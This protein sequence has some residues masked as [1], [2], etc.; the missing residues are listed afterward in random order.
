M[1][2]ARSWTFADWLAGEVLLVAIGDAGA[3]GDGLDIEEDV[4]V[5]YGL[6]AYT[7]CGGIEGASDRPSMAERNE[8][9]SPSSR[10]GV[11]LNRRADS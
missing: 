1:T 10:P 3:E 2:G 6:A 5:R 7:D 8:S 9:T 4:D 11:V